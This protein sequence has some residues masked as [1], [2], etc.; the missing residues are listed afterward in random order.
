MGAKFEEMQARA[1]S[2]L[3]PGL[4]RSDILSLERVIH[5]AVRESRAEPCL[6]GRLSAHAKVTTGAKRE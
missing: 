1:S 6:S 2:G 5:D 4:S 3:I